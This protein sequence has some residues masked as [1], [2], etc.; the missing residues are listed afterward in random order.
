MYHTHLQARDF[1]FTNYKL[2]GTQNISTI[3]SVAYETIISIQRNCDHLTE[4][5]FT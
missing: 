3:R 2:Y 5:F 1:N 4:V